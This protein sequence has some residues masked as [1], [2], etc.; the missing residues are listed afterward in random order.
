MMLCPLFA[1]HKVH[2]HL[3]D[4]GVLMVGTGPYGPRHRLPWS[5]SG[6]GFPYY[7]FTSI[8]TTHLR[9]LYP[10]SFNR[11]EDRGRV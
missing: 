10:V 7:G 4:S 6:S 3:S 9:F 2:N 8:S 11:Q 5:K 1:T